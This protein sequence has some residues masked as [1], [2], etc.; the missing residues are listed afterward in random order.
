ME[1]VDGRRERYAYVYMAVEEPRA[2]VVCLEADADLRASNTDDVAAGGV[3]KVGRPIHALND[4]ES[5]TM[6]MHGVDCGL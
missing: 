6:E 4:M 5:M 3:D 1:H 2:W